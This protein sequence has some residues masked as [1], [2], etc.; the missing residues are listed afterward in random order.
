MN[1]WDEPLYLFI[2]FALWE[3]GEEDNLSPL[4][5]NLGICRVNRDGRCPDALR[6][7]VPSAQESC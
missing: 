2:A 4:G 6:H 7:K 3:C 5:C 1:E